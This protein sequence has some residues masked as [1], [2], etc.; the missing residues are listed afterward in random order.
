MRTLKVAKFAVAA[1][2][3]L[4]C[5]SSAPG[6]EGPKTEAQL[7]QMTA[8]WGFQLDSTSLPK[9]IKRVDGLCADTPKCLRSVFLQGEGTEVAKVGSG[10]NASAATSYES[11]AAIIIS[12]DGRRGHRIEFALTVNYANG[13]MVTYHAVDASAT[14][15]LDWANATVLNKNALLLPE[16][17]WRRSGFPEC[18]RAPSPVQLESV[19][20][21]YH[22]ALNA[23]AAEVVAEVKTDR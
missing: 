17:C 9:L 21:N 1:A 18:T 12:R 8:L 14:G 20:S 23:A 10:T 19:R 15:Q 3:C 11:V 4:T 16:W 13:T 5:F 7:A 22:S 2:L 6:A